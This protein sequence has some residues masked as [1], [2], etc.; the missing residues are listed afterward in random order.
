[1]QKVLQHNKLFSS[2]ETVKDD[3]SDKELLLEE[4]VSS[5]ETVSSLLT[6]KALKTES[7]SKTL[8]TVSNAESV[9]TEQ[10]VS[11]LETVKNDFMKKNKG[12][13]ITVYSLK[14]G[15]GKT[16]ISLNLALELD[17]GVIT[18]DFYSP[19]ESVLPKEHVLK[20]EPNQDLPGAKQLEGADIIF[21]FGGYLDS[22]VVPALKM[23]KCV[24]IPV[25]G[26]DTL[27]TAGFVHT[28]SEVST[29][30]NNIIIVLNRVTEEKAEE[31]RAELKKHKYS[32][33]IFEIKESKVMQKVVEQKKSVSAI[34]KQ[35]GLNKYFYK[36]I[37]EQFIK[38][39][40]HINKQ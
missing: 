31:V 37:N 38:L 2:L 7:A 5:T 36:P 11:T 16:S 22:R 8:L 1:M 3:L 35:S 24:I 39:I 23:S 21:D 28:I 10:T 14:G 9:S 19:I 15:Q 18:N 12:T 17:Y 4:T 6:V 29:Y 40:N 13:K 27:S 32:Y 30:N 26:F 34:V 20:L 25:T 33:P